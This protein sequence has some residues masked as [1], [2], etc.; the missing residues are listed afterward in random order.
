MLG[1]Y[2]GNYV[3]YVGDVWTSG[4]I[5]GSASNNTPST[6]ATRV[7]LNVTYSIQNG[8]TY[9]S[10]AISLAVRACHR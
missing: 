2:G 9:D 7:D 6:E 1:A 8:V 4:I 5:W 3:M 10:Y